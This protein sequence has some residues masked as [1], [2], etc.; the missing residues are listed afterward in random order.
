MSA[1]P[2]GAESAEQS[3]SAK[4]GAVSR[5]IQV[6][7]NRGHLS[8]D[9]DPLGLMVRPVPEVMELKHFGLND[10]DLDSEF[11]PAVAWNRFLSG[12]SCAIS[13]RI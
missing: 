10:A 13:S 7:A 12:K 1:V 6:Y 3:A 11:L 4:Q 2:S 5:L 9:I 8:A